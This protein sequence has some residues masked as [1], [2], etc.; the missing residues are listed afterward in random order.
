MHLSMDIMNTYHL[1]Y[2]LVKPATLEQDCSF[3]EM[4]TSVKQP[5]DWFVI[6]WW[7]DRLKDV[8]RCL[9]LQIATR[10]LNDKTAF[11]F[12]A[13]ACRQHSMVDNVGVNPE[14]TCY[15]RAMRQ[16]KFQVLLILDSKTEHSG[17]ATPF[18]RAWCGYEMSMGLGS[19]E[20][21][22]VLDVATCDGGSSTLGQRPS[23]ITHNL[24]DAEKNREIVD[25]G[26]GYRAKAEREKTFSLEIMALALDVRVQSGQTLRAQDKQLILNSI[27][28]RDLDEPAVVKHEAYD[29]YNQRLRALFALGFWRRVMMGSGEQ[30]E[31]QQL[32]LKMCRALQA[33]QWRKSLTIDMAFMT[34]SDLDQKIQLAVNSLPPHLKELKLDLRG[35]DTANETI[36][37]IANALPRGL[38]AMVLD[39]GH[40]PKIDNSGVES[41]VNRL[42]PTLTHCHLGLQGCGT[43]KELTEKGSDLGDVKQYMAAEAAKGVTCNTLNLCPS[44]TRRMETFA[45][46]FKLDPTVG[47]KQ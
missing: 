26:S 37:A 42:P 4:L 2:W 22:L 38:E 17:P 15:F 30:S 40:N 33:D 3:T 11:W 47:N 44:P 21:S 28:Q 32:Q 27:T 18:K 23:L 10:E 43:A 45:A 34:G 9:E 25:A 19:G 20:N 7:G 1:N 8:L 35:T 16:A 12:G 39:L 13:L 31:I 24:T 14:D 36:I 5:A 6:H 46:K 29:R 41:M